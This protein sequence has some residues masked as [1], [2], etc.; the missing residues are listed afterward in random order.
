[1]KKHHFLIAL[2]PIAVALLFDAEFVADAAHGLEP[3][4]VCGILLDLSAQT[5]DL[6]IDRAFTHIAVLPGQFMAGDGFARPLGKDR[7]DILL[8][9]GEL[10]R[11]GSLLQF[12]TRNEKSIR[13]EHD[14]FDLSAAPAVRHG[15][16]YC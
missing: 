10:D 3:D 7:H 16:R 15:A 5:V 8:A 4:R 1:M 6:H 11:L 13:A 9:V 14:L 2:F 12:A